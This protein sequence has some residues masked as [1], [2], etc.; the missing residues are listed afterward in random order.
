VSEMWPEGAGEFMHSLFG[1]PAAMTNGPPYTHT[2]V[3]PEPVVLTSTDPEPPAGT[4]VRDDL[5]TRWQRYGEDEGDYWLQVGDDR[6][7]PESWTKIAG[8][9]GPVTVLEWGEPEP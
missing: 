7:D 6:A 3:P 4:I 2:I 5:G 9:Y 8:N 1:D